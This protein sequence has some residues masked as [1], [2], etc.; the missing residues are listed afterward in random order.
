MNVPT[1]T[2]TILNSNSPIKLVNFISEVKNEIEE[3]QNPVNEDNFMKNIM[4]GTSAS[5]ITG[6]STMYNRTPIYNF[7]APRL[8]S[9]PSIGSYFP[10]SVAQIIE[11]RKIAEETARLQQLAEL[12]KISSDITLTT[13]SSRLGAFYTSIRE[14]L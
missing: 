5:V 14:G 12:T 10:Q 9:L 4:L 6:L 1:Q 11:A 8:Q 3:G 13:F 2:D 7:L